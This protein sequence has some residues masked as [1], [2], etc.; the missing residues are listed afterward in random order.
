MA[1]CF[2]SPPI[3]RTTKFAEP[4]I[5]PTGTPI[6]GGE[7]AGALPPWSVFWR[8]DSDNASR[9]SDRDLP[10]AAH[11]RFRFR[12]RRRRRPLSEGARH[13]PS[14]CLALHEGAQGLHPRLRHRRSH[15]AQSRARR[16]C[17][18]RAAE[19]GAAAARHR[20]DPR[21]RAQPCR[22]AFR[23]QSMVARRAG[24]GP[25]LAARG[26]VRYRLGPAAVPRP[27][28]RAAADHRLV[29]RAG[30]GRAA[31]SSCATTRPKAASPP[32]ISSTG[33]RSRPSATARSCATL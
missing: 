33:C 19:R 5:E 16:R 27:R 30:A 14:L 9:H 25:G 24:M 23:R 20:P 29:L 1:P 6:W 8:L 2:G 26:F 11:R 17:R 4:E 12:R 13:Q 10:P 21:F 15:Q 3:C 32:G 7:I 28:R 18:L 22:R 31:R